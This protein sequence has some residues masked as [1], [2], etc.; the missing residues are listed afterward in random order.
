MIPHAIIT[1]LLFLSFSNVILAREFC[2]CCGFGDSASAWAI[3]KK[4][5]FVVY[6]KILNEKRVAVFEGGKPVKD[7]K[8]VDGAMG[9]VALMAGELQVLEILY[10]DGRKW[11]NQQ[12]I[13]VT[14]TKPI[15]W[16]SNMQ[17]IFFEKE[18]YTGSILMLD[19]SVTGMEISS[20]MDL[21]YLDW[22]R[23]E[24]DREIREHTLRELEGRLAENLQYV[25][26]VQNAK[27][28]SQIDPFEP[29]EESRQKKLAELK[30]ETETIRKKLL[31]IQS[32]SD[33]DAPELHKAT[34]H[35]GTGQ[36]ATRSVVEPEGGEKPQPEAEGRSR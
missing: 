20:D 19:R 23:K 32:I 36:P 2:P 22:L 10:H 12:S 6:G 5:D 13:W 25:L 11:P 29:T 16:G 28:L 35:P 21:K 14:Y 18:L 8:D 30:A 15:N 31:A 24:R 3:A 7:T 27:D 17:D 4:S 34:E 9:R 26:E 33:D 1:A